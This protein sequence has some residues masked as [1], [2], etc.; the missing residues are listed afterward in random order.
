M[1]PG[2]PIKRLWPLLECDGFRHDSRHPLAPQFDPK[3]RVH[4]ERS[5][6]RRNFVRS[7]ASEVYDAAD[8]LTLESE[9]SL[10]FACRE[11]LKIGRKSGERLISLNS[12]RTGGI[13]VP[14]PNRIRNLAFWIL[15]RRIPNCAAKTLKELAFL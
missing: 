10:S 2:S 14:Q 15:S 13:V 4:D 8:V 1:D 3:L 12:C 7:P 5:N 9:A 11:E 6:A